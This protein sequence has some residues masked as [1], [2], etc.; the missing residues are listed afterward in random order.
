MI[1]IAGYHGRVS[2]SKDDDIIS[3]INQV[4]REILHG[5]PLIVKLPL[6][7]NVSLLLCL[8]ELVVQGVTHLSV[9]NEA[10][11]SSF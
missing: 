9:G 8:N 4:T 2:V 5:S 3:N 11:S 6:G 7:G 10:C 1:V